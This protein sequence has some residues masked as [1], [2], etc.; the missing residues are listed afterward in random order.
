MTKHNAYPTGSHDTLVSPEEA[1]NNSNRDV[2]DA[3]Y[4]AAGE[5]APDTLVQETNGSKAYIHHAGLIRLAYSGERE[6]AEKNP[7]RLP[8]NPAVDKLSELV[9][10][11]KVVHE[12]VLGAATGFRP[13]DDPLYKVIDKAWSPVYAFRDAETG[14]PVCYS[15]KADAASGADTVIVSPEHVDV[16]LLEEPEA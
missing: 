15:V 7:Y 3:I 12:R 14:E 2:I 6:E 1:L 4:G 8:V 13:E 11:G 5:V 10:S 9:E 16:A